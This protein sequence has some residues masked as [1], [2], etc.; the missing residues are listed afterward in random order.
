MTDRE[1]DDNFLSRWSRRKAQ[2]RR[3]AETPP[4]PAPPPAAPK[5]TE[6]ASIAATEA[7]A[8]AADARPSEPPPTLADVARLT[9]NSDF[10]RF[11]AGDV[12]ADVKNA[13][14][15]KLFANPHFN[16][17]DGLDVYIDD[18]SRP[19]PIPASM[20][21]SIAQ[22][23]LLGSATRAEDSL[24]A[25][26]ASD[27]DANEAAESLARIDAPQPETIAPDENADLQLQPHDAAGCSGVEPGTDKDGR[28]EQRRTG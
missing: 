18:Y 13:A 17:M 4:T 20:L 3:A 6:P 7:P 8:A 15:K 23:Q 1:R 19:D 5:P 11:V 14:L 28:H 25:T 16:V 27:P 10:T 24:A 21:A 2:A 12:D 9:P 26:G 22:A